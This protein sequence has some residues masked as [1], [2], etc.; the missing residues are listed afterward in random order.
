MAGSQ[1]D[2]PSLSVVVASYNSRDTIVGC[3]ESLRGQKTGHAYEI[4]VVDSSTDGTGGLVADRFPDVVLLQSQHRLFAGGARNLGM[5]KA[6]APVIAF[7]DADCTVGDDWVDEVMAAQVCGHATVTGVIDNG[8]RASVIA[9]VYY[10]CEFNLWLPNRNA[11]QVSEAAGCCLSLSRSVFDR[12]GPFLEGTYCS[13]TAFHWKVRED[14]QST[15][16]APRIRVYH[17]VA[18]SLP[19]LLVHI[20]H[21]RR[22]YA[23]V[24]CT[25]KG[26]TP[27]GRLL[28]LLL[29]PATPL[30]LMGAVLLRLRRCP[31]YLPIF[32][33]LSPVVFLGFVARALGEAV[34]YLE[35]EP[36]NGR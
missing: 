3:L 15:F 19:S 36:R 17:H 26:L 4:L 22:Y 32:L 25:V 28:E 18:G 33:G 6:R 30:L 27:G 13:D 12:Y 24:K 35:P 34:G 2:P 21:H 10:F 1:L 23:R 7:M 9:W 20:F 5:A 16:F 11:R 8:S 29:L 31:S 14:G